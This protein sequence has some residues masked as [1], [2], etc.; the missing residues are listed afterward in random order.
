LSLGIVE[1]DTRHGKEAEKHLRSA[2]AVFQRLAKSYPERPFFGERLGASLKQLADLFKSEQQNDQAITTYQEA[3]QLQRKLVD[4]HPAVLQHRLDLASVCINLGN[5]RNR[6]AQ[7]ALART[8]FDEVIHVFPP[9]AGS[10]IDGGTR[11]LL[12]KAYTGRGLALESLG[13]LKGMA[14]DFEKAAALAPPARVRILRPLCVRSLL[15]GK[16]FDLALAVGEPL[17]VDSGLNGQSAFDLSALFFRAVA[18]IKTEKSK[19]PSDQAALVD[20]T[21]QQGLRFLK[22]ADETGYFA[23]PAHR[24]LL[25]GPPFV[26]LLEKDPFYRKL[27]EAASKTT[28]P[29]ATEPAK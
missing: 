4:A 9:P 21:I 24:K 10:K 12:E 19:P 25:F 7:S 15:E 5:L 8:T 2:I 27:V 26:P 18:G 1:T 22:R 13:D 23:D 16:Q 20:R 29:K 11:S 28:P 14:A 17:A 6:L 3:I